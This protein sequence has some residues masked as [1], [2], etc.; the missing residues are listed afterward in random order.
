MKANGGFV[1]L[2][3]T[4]Q[5]PSGRDV[6]WRLM[7]NGV[8]LRKR[9]NSSAFLKIANIL[10]GTAGA[11]KLH[12]DIAKCDATHFRDWMIDRGWAVDVQAQSLDG[13]PAPSRRHMR[14]YSQHGSG[15]GRSYVGT[16][17]PGILRNMTKSE[18]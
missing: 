12:A 18:T 10:T 11:Y 13:W 2:T 14:Q 3:A 16:R 15:A 7:S 1:L 17:T 6:T 8:I 5:T 4:K 9:A